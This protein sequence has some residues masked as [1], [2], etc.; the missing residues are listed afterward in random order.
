MLQNLMSEGL[1][2]SFRHFNPHGD[3]YS[4]WDY[5][6]GGYR[7]NEGLRIDLVLASSACLDDATGCYIDEKPR[8]RE[9]PSDHTP[10]VAEFAKAS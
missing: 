3:H 6:G 8:Q 9:R 4:W 1:Y 5:R 2:D 7:A 10:V